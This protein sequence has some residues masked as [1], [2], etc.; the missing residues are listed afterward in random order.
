MSLIYRTRDSSNGDVLSIY[1]NDYLSSFSILDIKNEING[2]V[3]APYYRL[4][5]L[6]PD[7]TIKNIL[8]SEDILGGTY[9]ENYQNGQRRSLS[10]ELYNE[11]GRYTPS[12][13]GLW[14]DV[15]FS[16]EIGIELISGDIIWFSR[17]VY[18][19]TSISPS[20]TPDSKKVSV[21]M[22]DKFSILE[23]AM[24]TLDESYT[25][26]VGS[27]IYEAINDI[28][29][30]SKGNGDMLDNKE[31]VFPSSFYNKKTQAEI[32]KE[33]GATYG[34]IILDLATQLSS[35]VFYDV[36]GHLTFVPIN[37]ISN[38]VDK[39]IVFNIYD[40]TGDII[41]SSL[42][43]DMSSI[44]NKVVVIGSNFNGNICRAV[45]VNDNPDSPLCFQRIGYRTA[46]IIN[47]PNITSDVLAQD[48]ADYELRNK[49]IL[50]ASTT[51]ETVFNPLLYVNNL[52]GVTD[53]DFDFVEEKF[54]IQSINYSLDTNGLMTIT[55]SNIR[56]L[57]F[58]IK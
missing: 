29:H 46:P 24:G 21:E 3:I 30:I 19:I 20:H 2:N 45:A 14:E 25:I 52:I 40:F 56:N 10:V 38:D 43:F 26:P 55:C 23:G 44:F 9:S 57:P 53:E 49:L 1:N 22:S 15:K 8:P 42:S 11:D 5:W 37:E 41:N 47:D 7:E 13:N 31:I 18:Y 39:P 6:N 17:G 4:H 33:A 12:I 28:L 58:T 48:R 54:L 34:S 35:E 50:K 16:F 51:I 27:N 36:Q 32:K